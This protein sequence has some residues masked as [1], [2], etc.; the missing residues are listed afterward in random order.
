MDNGAINGFIKRHGNVNKPQLVSFY[1][2]FR[3]LY[4]WVSKLVDVA[5]GLQYLHSFNFVH[6]DLKGVRW[7]DFFSLIACSH[8]FTG[9]HPHKG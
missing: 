6:G 7:L 4:N 3:V 8:K 1:V 2:V 9:E 5:H